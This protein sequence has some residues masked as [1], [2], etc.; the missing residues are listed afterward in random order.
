MEADIRKQI[1]NEIME[2]VNNRISYELKSH[3]VEK[4]SIEHY[5]IV[6]ELDNGDAKKNL[7]R[8]NHLDI[9]AKQ[10]RQKNEIVE[11]NIDSPCEAPCIHSV[12]IKYKS[13]LIVDS[14]MDREAIIKNYQTF[15]YF[16]HRMHFGVLDPCM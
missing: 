7:E 4:S 2:S 11:F 8:Q 15:L 16:P 13:G 6:R 5:L 9:L 10:A 3:M 12:Y 1:F 14:K